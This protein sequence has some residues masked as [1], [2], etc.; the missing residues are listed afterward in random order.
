MWAI[1][2]RL[3]GARIRSQMQYKVSFL[4][5]LLGFALTTG[6]E[7]AIIAILFAR[8]QSVGGWSLFEVGLLY[9]LT[10]T[11]FGLA[12]M[13]GRGF[14]APFEI[15]MQRGTFDTLLTRPLGT[16]LQVLASEFQLRRL[17]R[18]FQGLAVLLYA[19]GQLPID[20]TAAKLLVLPLTVVSGVVIYMGLMV[21]GATI[22]FW[23]IKTP[24]VINIFTFGGD[25]LVSYP[26]SIYNRWIR[27]VFLFVVPVAFV[28]YPAAL[29]LLDRRD[30]NGLPAWLAWAAPLVAGLFFAV[31]RG[32][33]QIGVAKY[34]SAGS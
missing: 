25:F 31:A 32:F 30:P 26:L 2:W 8:F 29:L 33:W 15:M 7:F 6:M 21:I 1:Y 28:N 23:T 24:E 12:E 5:E 11:A 17:G 16:F 27:R 3:I 34:T 13:I 22:C 14:D 18:T 20:W 4:L 19:L 10:S 9:G